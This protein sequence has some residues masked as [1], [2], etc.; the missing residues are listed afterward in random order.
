MKSK[1]K[2]QIFN[3]EYLEAFESVENAKNDNRDLD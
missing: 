3:F 2:E 1:F